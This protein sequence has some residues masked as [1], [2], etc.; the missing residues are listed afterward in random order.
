VIYSTKDSFC[1]W[2]ALGGYINN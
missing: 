2:V 1:M